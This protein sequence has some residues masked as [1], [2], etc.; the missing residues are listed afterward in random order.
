MS[1]RSQKR[2]KLAKRP[3]AAAALSPALETIKEDED[4]ATTLSTWQGPKALPSKAFQNASKR[5][6]R[7]RKTKVSIRGNLTSTMF[8]N[9]IFFN[10]TMGCVISY[11]ISQ[12]FESIKTTTTSMSQEISQRTGELTIVD[13]PTAIPI[14]KHTFDSAHHSTALTSGSIVL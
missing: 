3:A 11:Q 6:R 4:L 13:M 7:R 2:N 10:F 5:G 14:I 9:G 1:R 8:P 12:S